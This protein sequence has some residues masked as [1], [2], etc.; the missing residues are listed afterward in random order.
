MV[1]AK[2]YTIDE[3]RIVVDSPLTKGFFQWSCMA[4]WEY[5]DAGWK[6]AEVFG[7]YNLALA[8]WMIHTHKTLDRTRNTGYA[9]EGL[10]HAYRVARKRQHQA[11][12]D[13]LAYT[14]DRGLFQLASW[15]LGGPLQS[16]NRFLTEHPTDDPLAVG[17]IMNHRREPLLRIDVVQ[18]QMHAVMLALQH[19]ET[20]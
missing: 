2:D 9:Y 11:A 19:L 20:Q 13:D 16:H 18:H 1:L 8:W 3:W 14:I 12:M 17:G 15:Q 10:I 7:D 4:F 5:Y 6:H